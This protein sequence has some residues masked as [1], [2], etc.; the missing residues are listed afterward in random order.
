MAMVIFISCLWLC[1]PFCPLY[2]YKQLFVNLLPTTNTHHTI[3]FLSIEKQEEEKQSEHSFGFIPLLFEWNFFLIQSE[4]FLKS[5]LILARYNENIF[6]RASKKL[7]SQLR[8]WD[9]IKSK[10]DDYFCS[11]KQ[12]TFLVWFRFQRNLLS[13]T[14]CHIFTYCLP[15]FLRFYECFKEWLLSIFLFLFHKFQYASFKHKI[16][17]SNFTAKITLMLKCGKI[18]GSK[19]CY[20]YFCFMYVQWKL[21]KIST[22]QTYYHLVALHFFLPT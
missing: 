14:F 1:L 5:I 11:F 13:D 16:K 22:G 21:M 4:W 18:A 8:I 9:I 10:S 19:L 6:D 20:Y 3:S 2:N 15:E 17:C 7:F 12:T